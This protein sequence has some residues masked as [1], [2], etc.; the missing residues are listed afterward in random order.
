[1][2]I[3]NLYFFQEKATLP[4]VQAAPGL[5][6]KQHWLPTSPRDEPLPAKKP[7]KQLCCLVPNVN[8]SFQRAAQLLWCCS[9]AADRQL[10]TTLC[11]AAAA[12]AEGEQPA[13]N[14]RLKNKEFSYKNGKVRSIFPFS[15]AVWVSGWHEEMPMAPQA[16][17]YQ[18]NTSSSLPQLVIGIN[19]N[20]M[21]NIF[22]DHVCMCVCIYIYLSISLSGMLICYSKIRVT[23]SHPKKKL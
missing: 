7:E 21:L 8:F 11:T 18:N 12:L 20:R 2:S 22:Q 19:F 1:M 16:M 23:F 9:T 13:N 6:W 5:G 15:L 17:K 10:S 14:L 4:Q 3:I